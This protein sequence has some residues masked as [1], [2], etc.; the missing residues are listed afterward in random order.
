MK[1]KGKVVCGV[2][3]GIFVSTAVILF[4]TKPL[5]VALDNLSAGIGLGIMFIIFVLEP[6]TARYLWKDEPILLDSVV[7]FLIRIWRID[8]RTKWHNSR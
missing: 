8:W 4:L 3:I 1:S 6:I 2:G 7:D 5:A